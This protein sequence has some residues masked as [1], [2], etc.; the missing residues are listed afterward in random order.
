M[1]FRNQ[2]EGEM[3][4]C[5][6]KSR[7]SQLCKMKRPREFLYNTVFIISN[8]LLYTSNIF[9]G[10][11][12]ILC[13]LYDYQKVLPNKSQIGQQLQ[14]SYNFFQ[15]ECLQFAFHCR[16]NC[17]ILKFFVLLHVYFFFF[18]FISF[19]IDVQ[20]IYNVLLVSVIQ[21]ND[22][23]IYIFIYYICI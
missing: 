23:V 11:H 7:E 6:S 2:V 18:M 1:F 8:M 22:S 9:K 13:I 17:R 12:L 15:I 3:R 21:H 19:G 20:F 10:V 16:T 14:Y 5:T 4:G